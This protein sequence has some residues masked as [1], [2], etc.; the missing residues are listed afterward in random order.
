MW[1]A[2]PGTVADLRP[3]VSGKTS[4]LFPIGTK[5]T[6]NVCWSSTQSIQIPVTSHFQSWCV[7]SSLKWFRLFT[8][9]SPFW[10][11]SNTIGTILVA[12]S[13]WCHSWQSH[14]LPLSSLAAI[15]RNRICGTDGARNS[16]GNSLSLFKMMT[17]DIWP[18]IFSQLPSLLE[19]CRLLVP[20]VCS[21]AE[22]LILSVNSCSPR[23]RILTINLSPDPTFP[24]EELKRKQ[25][26][27]EHRYRG[28]LPEAPWIAPSS[29]F[30][31]STE[32]SIEQLAI[33]LQTLSC[34]YDWPRSLPISGALG[35]KQ[36][37]Q[38][39]ILRHIEFESS[40]RQDLPV[41]WFYSRSAVYIR[42]GRWPDSTAQEDD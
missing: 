31:D 11:L 42:H 20:G 13:R 26:T 7:I 34:Q 40:L 18:N 37:C 9:P 41:C 2:S 33:L 16:V 32:N 22:W 39:A 10:N 14:A 15:L 30:C 17:R 3:S 28:C 4:F 35:K 1:L 36:G 27:I 23:G 12:V 25:S 38:S 5:P 19:E 21:P 24:Q 8:R 29:F 6:S